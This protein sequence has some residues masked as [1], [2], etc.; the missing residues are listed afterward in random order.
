VG[1]REEPIGA[2][3]IPSNGRQG[4]SEA[5]EG[6][7][8]SPVPEVRGY[9]IQ[10]RLGKGGMGEVYLARQLALGRSVAIKFLMP[11][12]EPD[13][14]HDLA[15]FR[16]EAE[17]MAKVSHPNVLSIYDFGEADGR[18][19]LVMEYVQGGDLR[20]RMVAGQPMPA[21]Q[22][23]SIVIPVGEALAYLHR[24]G[25]IH[26]DLKP[27]NILLHDGDHPRVADFGIA[28]LRT[29]AGALTQTGWCVGTLGYVAPE[30]QYRLKVDERADQYSLAALSY[31][32]L[33]GQLPLGIFKPPSHL[34]PRLGPEADAAILRALQESPRDRFPTICE[35][36]AALDRGLDSAPPS[37]GRPA[38]R[39]IAGAG[40]GLFIVTGAVTAYLAWPQRRTP[41]SSRGFNTALRPAVGPKAGPSAPAPV[42]PRKPP[43]PLSEE[44][45]RLRARK[46]W[47]QRGKPEG[48][49]VQDEIWFKAVRDVE[50]E[51]KELAYGVW[52]ERGS[53]EG[54]A[55]D[56]IR[57]ECWHE[58]E[59]RL[60]KKLAG[61]D[62]PEPES[63]RGQGSATPA[64][65]PDEA[66]PKGAESRGQG[67]T[68]AG[69][70]DHA[71][72][73]AQPTPTRL[74]GELL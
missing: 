12:G 74:P 71:P 6:G 7:R 40:L 53:P 65:A 68:G 34:N 64:V 51:L 29:G 13:P 70:Q 31:E 41:A 21:D 61:R 3:M 38:A 67:A 43:P 55:G 54:P 63:D 48:R 37:R 22:V 10:E 24:H 73:R 15:R 72:S 69:W 66:R 59:R 9:E 42:T 27:E 5:T 14:D 19:Y 4:N 60:Y 17:L 52:Q 35:F 32:M 8:R 50:Q 28:V 46:I 57:D 30:Q 26:R 56:A 18:P 49:A 16:R 47:E 23:R 2:G 45:K 1:T 36:T 39:W 33:T 20:R 44:L 58:A 11:E 25:I 62:P